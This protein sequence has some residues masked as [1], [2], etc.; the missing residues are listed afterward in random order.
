MTAR[1]SLYYEFPTGQ[2]WRGRRAAGYRCS[3]DIFDP[4][5]GD[6]AEPL[7]GWQFR[8]FHS[9]ANTFSYFDI[10]AGAC[11][12]YEHQHGEEETW[13][14]LAGSLA[15]TVDGEE[16]IVHAGS[17]IV[18]PPNVSHSVRIIGPCRALVVDAPRR[19]SLAGIDLG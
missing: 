13:H 2:P 10:D 8:W 19:S 4:D 17:A 5:S 15:V 11:D 7:P 18:V 12:L 16:R 6:A 3:V 14:I 9:A 1:S